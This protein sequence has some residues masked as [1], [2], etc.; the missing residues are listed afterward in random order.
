VLANQGLRT[1]EAIAAAVAGGQIHRLQRMGPHRRAQ[2]E[3][4]LVQE[5]GKSA[6]QT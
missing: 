4:W 3:T 5:R 2:L 1:F 6:P